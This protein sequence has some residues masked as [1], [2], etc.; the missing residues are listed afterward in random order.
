MSV[1]GS[2]GRLVPV[3]LVALTTTVYVPVSG[4]GS[5]ADVAV[6]PAVWLPVEGP[7]QLMV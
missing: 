4:S 1:A 2:D 5:A 7:D 3:A 6:P